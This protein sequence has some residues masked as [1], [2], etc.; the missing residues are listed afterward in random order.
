MSNWEGKPHFAILGGKEEDRFTQYLAALL[1]APV[2]LVAFLKNVC[3]LTLASDEPLSARTQVTVPGGRPDLAIRG[4]SLYLLYEAK[5][6]SWLHEE[7]L[8]PYAREL[9]KWSQT[10]PTGTA[11]LFLLAPQRQVSAIDQMAKRELSAALLDRWHPTFITWEEIAVLFQGLE[12]AV[13]DQRLALHLREFAEVVFFRLGEPSRPFTIEEC[14]MLED[15]LAGKAL[16]RARTLVEQVTKLL[17]SRGVTFSTSRG[18]LYEGYGAKYNG[19]YWWYGI[20]IDAWEK[21]GGSPICFQLSGFTNRPQSVVLEGLPQPLAVQIDD[22][23]QVVPLPVRDG[24]ELDVLA[25]EQAE[26][27]WR[28]MTELPQSGAV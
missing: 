21:I 18:F 19:R 22:A 13:D 26:I 5:M 4:E 28:Y 12:G 3:R 15:P 24:V 8:T 17:E 2:V 11:R 23:E 14:R 27:V 7:Q 1:R 6:A 9:D 10:H 20:W 25:A 16:R